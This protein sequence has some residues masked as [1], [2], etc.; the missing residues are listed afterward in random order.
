M[1][2][3]YPKR[4]P[5]IAVKVGDLEIGGG[6]TIKLQ[7]MTT[8]DTLDIAAT[9][10]Q[11]ISCYEAGA[12]LVRITAPSLKEAA[13]LRAIKKSLRAQ[14][15]PVPLVAD[16]HYTPKAAELT[17]EFLEKVRINPGNYS[18]KK[19]FTVIH[20]TD[21]AYEQE[22]ERIAARFIPL[23]HICKKNGT[24]L[25]IGTN[26]GSLSDR[27]LSRYGDTPM[28]MVESAM[29]FLRIARGEGFHQIVLSMKASN[30]VVM[31][32]AYRLLAVQMREEFGVLYP[33]HLGVTEAGD[34]MEGRIK[35]AIGV[36]M[37]LEEGIGDTIRISLT[38]PP[39][40]ELPVAKALLRRLDCFAAHYR[41]LQKSCAL[42][43]SAPYVKRKAT[44]WRWESIEIGAD[45]PLIGADIRAE[46]AVDAGC[47][48]HLA[49]D[50][51][52]GRVS[53]TAP[54]FLLLNP[55]QH[56]SLNKRV[57]WFCED[58]AAA[59]VAKKKG[60]A[61]AGL[62]FPVSYF[63]KYDKDISAAFS[64][65]TIFL[66]GDWET[67]AADSTL[68][69]KYDYPLIIEI[70]L[71]CPVFFYK[72]TLKT[73]SRSLKNP[74]I[75]SFKVSDSFYKYS[76][77]NRLPEILLDSSV[78]AAALFLE[79]IGDGL[80]L[81]G[82]GITPALANAWSF[83]ILQATRVRISKTEYI[84]CPSCGRTLFD[85]QSTTARIRAATGHLKGV[86]IAVMGCIVNGPGEMADADFGY[87]G[88]GVGKINLYKGRDIVE[89]N[90]ADET[91]VEALITLIKASGRWQEP[92][93]I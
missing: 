30:P 70:P 8:T 59:G 43:L 12:D 35:S 73:L 87:V 78:Q 52:G 65:H 27:I 19:K 40:A 15:C 18:D 60:G 13:A 25:R 93:H 32:A 34:G 49:I 33:L 90:I 7:T 17:A 68:L 53:D 88:S 21:T 86:K 50:E 14:G 89:K 26:H 1:A 74:L 28:G 10:R 44:V 51:K 75:F 16:I 80:L 9:V 39:E 76:A 84:S 5:T 3:H 37:L 22:I 64:A 31:I 36:G 29:E 67:L 48:A 56:T 81:S 23:L 85:L 24:A 69:K 58:R 46:G 42:S 47:L 61:T 92:V 66:Y 11:T 4:I 79:G 2:A 55:L 6:S 62:V 20:Y 82:A 83:G 38:E 41:H 71:P 45:I 57:L 91:A 54:D 77:D 63:K 72:D